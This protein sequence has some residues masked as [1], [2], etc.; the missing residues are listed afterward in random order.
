[1]NDLS[2]Y[3][4]DL[5]VITAGAE[6]HC[7]GVNPESH[8]SK[9]P[10]MMMSRRRRTAAPHMA[11]QRSF[12]RCDK[13]T[14]VRTADCEEMHYKTLQVNRVN[15]LTNRYHYETFPDDNKY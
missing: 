1:M 11:R 12:C 8:H 7:E 15:I 14:G 4:V 5:S 3:H 9:T 2:Y 10:T 6:C 13:N